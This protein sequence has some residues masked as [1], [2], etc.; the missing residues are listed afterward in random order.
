MKLTRLLLISSFSLVSVS[1]HAD[2][3][4]GTLAKSADVAIGVARGTQIVPIDA[5]ALKTRQL[6]K[7]LGAP[8]VLFG[9]YQDGKFVLDPSKKMVLLGEVGRS[10]V[11]GILD[12]ATIADKKVSIFLNSGVPSVDPQGNDWI[13]GKFYGNTYAIAVSGLSHAGNNSKLTA[14]TAKKQNA[15]Q[16][17]QA[18]QASQA[19]T[20]R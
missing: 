7:F 16:S 12:S 4:K 3:L 1:A 2:Y 17:A 19:G 5:S 6:Q 11:G 18:A 9:D 10:Q 15:A 14:K 20:K 13:E 8:V